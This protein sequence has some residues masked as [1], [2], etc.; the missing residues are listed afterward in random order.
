VRQAKQKQRDKIQAGEILSYWKRQRLQVLFHYS[1]GLLKCACCGENTYEF[2]SLDHVRGG[3]TAHRKQL[4]T[5]YILSYLIQ[6]GFP[7][8][9]QVLCH[10]CNQAKGFYLKCPHK[11]TSQEH[12][13]VMIPL[14]RYKQRLLE[15]QFVAPVD[16]TV[17]AGSQEN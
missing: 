11:R 6:A 5:R 10:N 14:L 12:S 4:G 3:G 2:L 9:Y 7:S 15:Q 8:G 13:L 1:G 16:G 17:V